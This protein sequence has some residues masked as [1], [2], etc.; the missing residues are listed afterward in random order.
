MPKSMLFIETF[1]NL[2]ICKTW[3]IYIY[4]SSSSFPWSRP[5]QRATR[6]LSIEFLT[7]PVVSNQTRFCLDSCTFFHSSSPH[8]AESPFLLPIPS[9]GFQ[10]IACR[11]TEDSS[12]RRVCPIQPHLC[13]LMTT[14]I[15]YKSVI[16]SIF[17]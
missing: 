12:F 5:G 16:F 7:V 2:K 14:S 4:V 8:L 11:A 13:L 10:F 9:R 3:N 15:S 6:Q 1:L 17:T